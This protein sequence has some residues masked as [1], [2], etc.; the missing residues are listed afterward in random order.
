MPDGQDRRGLAWIAAF[1]QTKER[2]RYRRLSQRVPPENAV[3]PGILNLGSKSGRVPSAAGTS[4]WDAHKSA[5]Q[6]RNLVNDI[7]SEN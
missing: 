2:R 7:G 4:T 6:V 5:T 3:R 1:S